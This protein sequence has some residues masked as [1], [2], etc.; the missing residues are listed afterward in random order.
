MDVII[1]V[2]HHPFIPSIFIVRLHLSAAIL[3]V[4]ETDIFIICPLVAVV[5]RLFRV[6]LQLVV[7]FIVFR[8]RL[9][10]VCCWFI[11]ANWEKVEGTVYLWGPSGV[12][13]L[14]S[15]PSAVMRQPVFFASNATA[16]ERTQDHNVS[17]AHP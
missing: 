17:P 15:P 16:N 4:R 11:I 6:S 7:L 12:I 8:G 3:N 9:N 1:E 14:S 13:N 5:V 2:F 10:S